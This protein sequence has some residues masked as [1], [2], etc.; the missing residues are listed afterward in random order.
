MGNVAFN[1]NLEFITE[2]C[3]NCGVPFAMTSEM[4]R[5]LRNTP[6]TAFYC[7]AGHGQH[8]TAKTEA[9]KLKEQLADESKRLQAALSRENQERAERQKA[10]RKLKRV[11]NG[12]CPCCTRSFTNLRRHIATRHPEFQCAKA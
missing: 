10:E 1:F 4:Q 12:V 11:K 9:Q 2:E 8:Y 6:G 3:C 7:P 5:R